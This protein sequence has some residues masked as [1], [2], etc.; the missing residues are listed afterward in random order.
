[1]ALIN[2]EAKE[3]HCKIV[4]Y[5]PSLSGKTTNIRWVY[6]TTQ[7]VKEKSGDLME[8]KVENP[9]RTY[10]FDFLPLNVGQIRDLNVRFHLYSVPGQVVYEASRR[11]LLKNL[12]ATVF[13][14]DLPKGPF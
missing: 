10:F 2:Q 6:Q 4:Y 1:M 8:F 12:D 5:G 7:G 14:A 9:E 13:V 11:L 3:L